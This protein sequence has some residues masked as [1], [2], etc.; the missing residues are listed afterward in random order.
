MKIKSASFLT[1]VASK[2]NLINSE[3]FEFAF[4]G[5]SNSGK[6]SL[7]N[8]L[9]NQKNLAKTSGTPGLTKLVN[10][11]LINCSEPE[12]KGNKFQSKI[13]KDNQFLPCF[14][15]DLP[16][17]GYSK[18][19]K[20]NHEL[21]S[22]LIEDYFKFSTSLKCVFVLMDIRHEPSVLDEQMILYLYSKN[23]PFKV[24]AT[25]AD[26]L[27]KSKI[28]QYLSQM[29]KKLKITS[30]NIIPTSSESKFNLNSVL[31]FLDNFYN[32]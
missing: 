9:V 4:V 16:G 29:A 19:G 21:W 20:F 11:F 32:E 7:I 28:N 15:V 25:K 6:S 27:A 18:A 17:Y 5:R 13:T 30:N 23:I 22:G 3:L 31:D 14:F 2:E 26:K 10:Y 8:A 24:I 12:F 1:S